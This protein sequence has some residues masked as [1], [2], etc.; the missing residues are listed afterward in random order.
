MF[1]CIAYVHIPNELHSKLE[2]KDKK[3]VFVGSSLEQKGYKCY[4]LV[5]HELRVTKD[6]IFDEKSSC[7]VDVNEL[8]GAKIKE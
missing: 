2:P 7:Y 5:I 3:C 1:R 8:I 6:A 4:N